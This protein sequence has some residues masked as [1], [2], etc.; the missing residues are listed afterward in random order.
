M[1]SVDY[2]KVI[3]YK[4][5]CK[6]LNVTECYVGHTTNF[7]NRKSEHKKYCNNVK[8]KKFHLKVYEIIRENKGWNNWD[9]IEM[10]KFPCK[11]FNEARARERHWYEIL[12]SSLNSIRP[13]ISNEEQRL[14]DREK[15]IVYRAKNHEVIQ[16]KK[17]EQILCECGL[18]A[19]SCHF[20]RHRRTKLH[21]QRMEEKTNT[22]ENQ[23][24]IANQ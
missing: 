21:Q 14:Y 18:Y 19:T 5:V 20:Q 10:E 13:L 22:E 17:S 2:S 12:N 24:A 16:H 15:A 7:K 8:S 6:D 4:I 23:E 3:I 11:D 9:M 1:P